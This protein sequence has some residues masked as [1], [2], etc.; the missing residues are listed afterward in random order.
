MSSTKRTVSFAF[1]AAVYCARALPAH[2][3]ARRRRGANELRFSSP[4]ELSVRTHA[5]ARARVFTLTIVLSAVFIV[6]KIIDARP[7][8]R[9]AS[10]PPPS[11][12]KRA[13]KAAAYSRRQNKSRKRLAST[14]DRF[15]EDRRR[16]SFGSI[17]KVLFG[18]DVSAEKSHCSRRDYERDDDDDEEDD[19][20]HIKATSNNSR[21]NRRQR[22]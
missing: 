15:Y 14:R 5:G 12:S 6:E 13:S 21:T 18:L 8:C 16:N 22:R 3:R 17:V 19:R 9:R 4:L 1:V 7:Q 10:S 20:D 2:S 11:S